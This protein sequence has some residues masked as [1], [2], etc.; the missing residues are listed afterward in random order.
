MFLD[1]D[2]ADTKLVDSVPNGIDGLIDRLFAKR[3]PLRRF[4]PQR[5]SVRHVA[6]CRNEVPFRKAFVQN[7]PEIGVL[8]GVHTNDLEL[9]VLGASQLAEND[10]FTHKHLANSFDS[11]VRLCPDRIVGY[12]LQHQVSPTLKIQ[13]EADVVFHMGD[14]GNNPRKGRNSPHRQQGHA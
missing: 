3:L 10:I 6:K 1:D 7:P 2:F 12:H 8:G 4:Q 11:L 14:R 5:V 9:I 13:P